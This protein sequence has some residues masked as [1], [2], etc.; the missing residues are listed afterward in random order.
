MANQ[1]EI[2]L[3]DELT[4]RII[5]GGDVTDDGMHIALDDGRILVITGAFVVG[6]VQLGK[7]SLQ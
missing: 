7:E 3:M 5:Y 6:L 2:A 1:S 4:G